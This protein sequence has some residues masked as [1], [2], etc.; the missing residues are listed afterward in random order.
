[1]SAFIIY[2]NEAPQIFY[3][4]ECSDGFRWGRPKTVTCIQPLKFEKVMELRMSAE[5]GFL[6]TRGRGAKSYDKS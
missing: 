3:W 1:M 6:T 4:Q 5:G 2:G